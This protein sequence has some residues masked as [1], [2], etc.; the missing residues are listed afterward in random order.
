M[1]YRQLLLVHLLN[2]L[3]VSSQSFANPVSDLKVGALL[4]LS[5]QFARIGSLVRGGIVEGIDPDLRLIVED[6]DC[7]PTKAVSS[8]KMDSKINSL[9]ASS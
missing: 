1:S 8:F 2:I 7:N 4:P 3:L 5:G 6:E 9:F